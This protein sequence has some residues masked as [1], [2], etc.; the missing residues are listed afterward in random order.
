[1]HT[2]R[3]GAPRAAIE[4]V[5]ERMRQADV[6]E[7]WASHGHKPLDALTSSV[8]NSDLV[9]TW[10]DGPIPV[11]I[12]GVGPY[13]RDVGTPWFLGTRRMY[14]P[15]A[16]RFFLRSTGPVLRTFHSMGYQILLQYVSA[17]HAHSLRWL[18]WAG[19]T[20]DCFYPRWG[21]EAQPFFRLSKVT[22]V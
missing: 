20:V 2:I 10:W 22:H 12:F 11:G 13:L 4:Y 6:E 17:S 8:D 5:A 21:Y 19:F 14:K 18:Q 15:A 1:M 3:P 9:Y 16:R 7:V